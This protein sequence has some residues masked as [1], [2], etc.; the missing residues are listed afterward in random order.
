[1]KGHVTAVGHDPDG[2]VQL[3]VKLVHGGGAHGFALGDRLDVLH[4]GSPVEP[5]ASRRVV[6]TTKSLEESESRG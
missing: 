4:D 5:L 3:T 1:M 6:N 2:S